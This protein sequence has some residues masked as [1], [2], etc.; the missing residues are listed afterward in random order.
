MP[1]TNIINGQLNN[2]NTLWQS[3]PT[4]WQ[5]APAGQQSYADLAARFLYLM[6]NQNDFR[7]V[8]SILD[9]KAKNKKKWC[10]IQ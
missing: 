2:I 3:T 10:C 9:P 4:T 5:G 6:D 7:L 8:L 1:F